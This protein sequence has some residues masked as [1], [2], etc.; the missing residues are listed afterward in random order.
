MYKYEKGSEWRVWDLHIHTPK[1]IINEYGS[2]N[3]AV[4]EK[5]IQRLEELPPAVKVIG[6]ND[7]YFIDGYE[8][9]YVL[10]RKRSFT[11]LRYDISNI[12]IQ[13]RHFWH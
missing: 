7:Y 9:S 1:S 8:K 3:N 5:F 2:N 10:S 12:R 11:K 6:I 13:G 4:W